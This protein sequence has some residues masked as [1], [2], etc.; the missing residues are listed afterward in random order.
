MNPKVS[1]IIPI[2]NVESYLQRSVSTAC[3][4][5]LT[6]IEI[7]LV[8]DGSPD[9]C[10]QMCDDFGARDERI[11]VIHKQNEG[12]GLA[13]NSGIEIAT[14]EYVYF[15][16]SDDYIEPNMIEDM[17]NAAKKYNADFVRVDNYKETIDGKIQNA[18]YIPPMREG[19]Y[20]EEE[21]RNE[22]L[23][24]QFGMRPN[25]SGDKYVS[26]SVWRNLYRRNIIEDNNLRFVSERELISEDIPFNLDFMIRAKCAVVINRKYYHY[27]VN[28]KSLTQ[29][30]KEDRFDKEVVLYNELK[31]RLRGY[32]IYSACSTRLERHLL[33]RARKSIKREL[34][35]NPDKK[36]SIQNVR[37]ILDTPE[38]R[39]TLETYDTTYLPMKYRCVV[40]AMKHK[41]VHILSLVK[42]KL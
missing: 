3:N 32:D 41:K 28:E 26:C 7:I 19:L 35:G 31:R 8:D 40:W 20:N 38:L 11:K 27:I 10:P 12:L 36:N 6:D 1:I 33:T 37:R 34:L 42:H 24:P 30:Y 2:Y 9:N 23:F 22:L 17:Y 16:D 14:G 13:R 25:D 21:L 18:G 15:F 4:Q 39:N 5:S 29:S